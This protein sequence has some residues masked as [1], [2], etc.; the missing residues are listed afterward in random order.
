MCSKNGKRLSKSEAEY[1][2]KIVNETDALG[3]LAV[4]SQEGVSFRNYDTVTFYRGVPYFSNDVPIM[5][6]K[7]ESV[8]IGVGRTEWGAPENRHAIKIGLGD[9]IN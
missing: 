7:T 1:L 4:I 5:T 8:G 6:F 2:A 9:R 3:F